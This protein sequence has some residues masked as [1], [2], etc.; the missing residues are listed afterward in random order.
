MLGKQTL[1][2]LLLAMS[3]S[4]FADAQIK[5]TFY[6]TNLQVGTNNYAVTKTSNR[7]DF[8]DVL[9]TPTLDGEAIAS[10]GCIVT[11][12]MLY[13]KLT[14]VADSYYPYPP[15]QGS[16][17][18]ELKF[19]ITQSGNYEL[20]M[21]GRVQLLNDLTQYEYP[22]FAVY[23]ARVDNT[24]GVYS[25]SG[26]TSAL[27]TWTGYLAAGDYK[28]VAG[29]VAGTYANLEDASCA[30]SLLYKLFPIK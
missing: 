23:L 20:V 25:Y 10:D 14:A 26:K 1:M 5:C 2:S 29:C 16:V 4:V 17:S 28:F 11:P 18:D 9:A 8:F 13:G 22:Y 15:F 6:E 21:D 27:Q 24:T 7:L 19:T 3:L 30:C 12:G